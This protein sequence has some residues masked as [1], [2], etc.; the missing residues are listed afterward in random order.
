MK[1]FLV[2]GARPNF[3]KLA[4]LWR[5]MHSQPE[6]FEPIIIHTGQHYERR[7]SGVFF[8]EL[9]LP[10]PDISLGISSGTHT[11]QTA[12]I[13]IEFEKALFEHRPDWVIVFGDVNSTVAAALVAAK[14]HI[15]V[16][17]VEAGLRS[18]DRSMPEELNRIVTD[19]L[20]DL[21]FT[22]CRDADDNLTRENIG[23]DKVHFVGNIM[24]DS[25]IFCRS[26]IDQSQIVTSL[27]VRPR[28]YAL[29]TLHRPANVDN[30]DLLEGF[31]RLLEQVAMRL[32]VVFPIHPRTR[33]QLIENGLMSRLSDN[34][35]M[36]LTEPLGYLDFVRLERDARVVLTDSGGVQEETTALGVPCLTMRENTERPITI[37]NGTNRLV[38]IRANIIL[39]NLDEVL[40]NA[41]LN[42]KM[43]PLWDGRAAERICDILAPITDQRRMVLRSIPVPQH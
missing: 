12:R 16:A 26:A 17:H 2:A 36:R 43:P 33:R 10:N 31:V 14:E 22:T 28:E 27:G 18:R 3:V 41:G 25:L 19:H 9:G 38:G 39:D 29:C 40:S 5:Q 23:S 11:Q 21:L 32:P 42:D 37:T 24:I 6:T 13:M 34:S 35:R 8:D 20:S 4:P 7:M 30:S 1:V 15:R